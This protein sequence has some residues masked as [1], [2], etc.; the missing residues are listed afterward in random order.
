MD[1]GA[2]KYF[3]IVGKGHGKL[4]AE[5][6]ASCWQKECYANVKFICKNHILESGE[7]N[8]LTANKVILATASKRFAALLAG[9]IIYFLFM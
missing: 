5:N 6:I 4:L 7:V 1:T 8:S 9:K 3:K 2:Q